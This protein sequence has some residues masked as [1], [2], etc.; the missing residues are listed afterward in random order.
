[1]ASFRTFSEIVSSMIERL[2]LTQ[3][4]L[5]TK[6]GT[7]SRD[8]FVDIQADQIDRLY[9]SISFVS[10][11]QS[12]ATTVGRDLDR[13]AANFGVSRNSGTAAT[14]I[15]VFATNSLTTDISIANGTTVRARNGMSFKVIGN[16]V[17]SSA[18]K[19][20]FSANAN[21]MRRALN[22]AG[23]S[24]KYAIEVSVQATRPGTS[25]NIASLQ[26]VSSDLP[27]NASAVNLTAISGG[28]S[29]EVDSSFRSRILSI[30]SGANTGTS[31]GYRSAALGAEGALDALVVEPGNSLMLR[32]GTETIETNDGTSRII[33][34]GTG[35][36]VDIYV[37]G[38]SLEE[39]TES[40]IYT[41][42]SGSGD[43]SDERND[44]VL[45][46]DTQDMERTS[47]ER[48]Y[49]AFRT[50]NFPLQPVTT[51]SSVSGSKSGLLLE[52][53]T[54]ESGI[55]TGNYELI[56]DYNPDTGGSPFGF[57][58]L[59][60][61]SGEKQV[62]GE[63]ISK[64]NLNSADALRY[65][66][67][68]DL[69]S[70]YQDISITSENANVSSSGRDYIQLN[71]FPIKK[72]SRVLNNTTGE[73]YSVESQGLDEDTGLNMDGVIEISG[74][75]LPSSAD[76]LSV[77]YT[78]RKVFDQ[79]IDY[80]GFGSFYQFVDDSKSDVVDWATSNGISM[81][82]SVILKTDDFIEYTVD[83]AY[84]VD[85]VLS[86]YRATTVEASI[87][88][89]T[90]GGGQSVVGIELDS[91][92]D[93]IEN[94]ISIVDSGGLEIYNT[95]EDDGS[96]SSRTIYLPSESVA[97]LV[98]D[99]T[100]YYNKVEIF[101]VDGADGFFGEKV[102]TL[103]SSDILAAAEVDDD[104]EDMYLTGES[105]YVKYVANI[106]TI[107][108]NISIDSLPINGSS[109]SNFLL[110]S[111]FVTYDNS[112]QP[113]YFGYGDSSELSSIVRFGP[114]QLAVTMSNV[115]KPGK[116]KVSGV[117]LTR[118]VF[119]VDAGVAMSGFE[120]T[121][122]S[123]IKDLLGL[124]EI[125]DTVSIARVDRVSVLDSNGDPDE[126]YDT[127]GIA[128]LDNTYSIG[129]AIIDDDLYNHQFAL[130]STPHNS[131]ISVSSGDTIRISVLIYNSD[132]I[133]ELYFSK[134][135]VAYTDKRFGRIDRIFVS[136][137]FR[138]SS[139]N[140]SGSIGVKSFNQ[141][142]S[143]EIYF[144]SYSFESP[145]EGER[146]TVSY[147]MNKVIAEA[148][149][150]IESVRPITADVLVKEAAELSLDVYGTVLIND[151]AISNATTVV[152]NVANSVV[153][154]LSTSKLGTIVDYSDIISV[155]TAISGVDSVNISLFN[156]SGEIGRKA[157]IKALDNQYISPGTIVFEVVSR[158]KFRIS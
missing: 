157:F 12:L 8:L 55:T 39:I 67:V 110:D 14:G 126:D 49:L 48:R 112:S 40:F 15:V 74:R 90:S 138:T 124:S 50:G 34:S 69:Y 133:E 156:E 151:N 137:G 108:P 153:S 92:D 29:R 13:L 2:K 35:G 142:Q 130:P 37:L 45:G 46:Q 146:I 17:M 158:E 80:G 102:I 20:R 63:V 9:R 22:L 147:N 19:S 56:K 31:T 129:N 94:I 51:I 83:V 150:A 96:F 71:H 27:F 97:T 77:D 47:E 122:K 21:R 54:D 154:L 88:T 75:S 11:K 117:T 25:G 10:E 139:G 3:P 109:V 152:E 38:K 44:T 68:K 5:D 114:T 115:L 70:I 91:S 135:G 60:F 65:L 100:V 43:A 24:S 118:A 104:V 58:Y 30:F 148:S 155:A 140:L 125:P 32:D 82:E 128:V 143:G 101:D 132:D 73:V 33:S 26:I 59:H 41:D 36:K 23:L 28:V 149:R 85:R 121:L 78:W 95:R 105:V 79:Y 116:I 144:A 103:P 81:E 4:N 66:D 89:V 107:F 16:Y 106:D 42:M 61:I 7:V 53:T 87:D 123:E 52:A 145:K 120:V 136:S 134:S 1:M 113:I 131:S 62:S 119:E 111:S 84:K 127:L 18:E 98:D 141:P 57:D 76:V 64:N 99:V 72:V 86:V 6:P 93:V